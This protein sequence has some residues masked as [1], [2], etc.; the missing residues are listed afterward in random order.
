MTGSRVPALYAKAVLYEKRDRVAYITL[1]RPNVLNALNAEVH[2]LLC[3]IWDDFES[4]DDLLV[5]VM[6][7][8]GTRAFSVGQDL[9]ELASQPP[10]SEASRTT[11]GSKGKPGWPR[12]TERFEVTKPLVAKVRGYAIGGGFEL[13]LACD[14]IVAS[15]DA[16]F[17]LPEARWGLV[18]GAGG[19]FRLVKELPWK[20]AMAHLLTGRAISADRAWQL[21]LISDLAEPDELDACVD[22]WVRDILAAAPLALRSIKEAAFRSLTMPLDEAFNETYV[23][24]ERRRGSADASEGPRAFREKRLPN[25]SG[26]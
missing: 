21:G 19:A 8:A 2:S 12:I 24:E 23:W 9:N 11:Y 6:M 13:A 22:G 20:S 26:R 25:W 18:P 17:S 10:G 1:N 4:D 3:E 14:V 16:S 7:G 15:R 5:G